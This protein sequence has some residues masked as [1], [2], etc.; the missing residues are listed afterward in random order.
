VNKGIIF[1][2]EKYAVHDGHGIRTLVFLKGCPLRCLWCANPEGQ[3]TFPQL[4]FFPNKC[5]G[6]GRCISVCSNQ[7]IEVNKGKIIMEWHKCKNC[8]KCVEVCPSGARGC[9]GKYVTP[10]EVLAE[11][12]KDLPF[13]NR[14][15]G[16]VTLSG[17][18]P[19]MQP[20]FVVQILKLCHEN[21]INTAIETSGYANEEDFDKVLSYTDLILFDIKH[22]D[23]KKHKTGTGVENEKILKNAKRVS[24]RGIPMVIRIPVIPGYNDSPENISNTAKF[25]RELNS[26]IRVELLPYHKLGVSKYEHMGRK[27]LLADNMIPPSSEKLSKLRKIIRDY[28]LKCDI[29]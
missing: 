26:L 19:L 8:L 12:V 28:G 4:I 14:S 17:G 16:G 22:M 18:E 20:N 25:A 6:C 13:Y 2:I 24:N 10:E 3:Y 5:I 7:A 21:Y 9:K 15:N 23:S 1:N 27:Y 29:L 11:V